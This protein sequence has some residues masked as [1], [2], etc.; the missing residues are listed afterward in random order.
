MRKPDP[1]VH[2]LMQRYVRRSKTAGEVRFI[3]DRSGDDK[4]WGWGTPG[5]TNREIGE[6][7]TFQSRNLKPLAKALRATLAAMGHSLSA[8][9]TFTRIKSATVSPDGSLGGKG[10]IQKIPEMRRAFMNAVEA[11][12]ALSDTLY[13]EIH[14][15]HWNPA[16]EEQSPRERDE[17][18]DIMDDV[19][20][21]RDNPEEWA[22]EEEAEMDEGSGGKQAA[23]QSPSTG[24]FIA[25]LEAQLHVMH[26]L[27]WLENLTGGDPVAAKELQEAAAKLEARIQGLKTRPRGKTA[28]GRVAGRYLGRHR[29]P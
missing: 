4:Q 27:Q 16:M 11:L 20:R 10:Y 13:D 14:A 5:P 26:N 18:K 22:E 29:G 9:D 17:V 7:F 28:V 2:H 8:Y 15:P 25:D 19:E 6:D 24:K 12:S 1:G 3:K 23:K 21:I